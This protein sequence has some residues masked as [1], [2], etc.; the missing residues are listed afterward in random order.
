M[1]DESEAQQ[2]RERE[3]TRR[4]SAA[5]RR[6]RPTEVDA[7]WRARPWQQRRRHAAEKRQHGT[8]QAG[9]PNEAEEDEAF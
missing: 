4:G 5:E 9:M 1:R 2:L 8:A 3:A 7:Q 6:R